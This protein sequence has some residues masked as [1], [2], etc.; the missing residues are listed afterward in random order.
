MS[1]QPEKLTHKT[2][3]ALAEAQSSAV[4]RGHSQLEPTHVFQALLKDEQGLTY[5][6]FQKAGVSLERFK[7]EIGQRV[8]KYPSVS[9]SG[10]GQLYASASFNKLFAQA[11]KEM[12]SLKD[13]YVSVE[14]LLL[15]AASKALK[16]SEIGSIFNTF[17]LSHKKLLEILT[18]IR[19]SHRV[20][21]QS[22]ENKYQ[23]LEKFGRDLTK[24][25]QEQKLDPVIGRDDEIRRTMQILSRRTKNNPVL[26]GSPGVGKTAVVEGLARRI[27]SGDVPEGLKD[28]KLIALDMGALVAGAKYR[29]EFEERLKSVIKEVSD[30]N[31]QIILFIDELHLLVGAGKTEGAMDASNLLK[32]ALA[33]GELRCIGATT[34]DEYRENIE[35]DAALERRFQKTLVDEPSLGETVSILRGLKERYEVHHGIAVRDAALVAAAQLSDRYITDRFLPDKAIDLVDEA[36]ARIRMEAQSRPEAIDNLERRILQLEIEREALKKESDPASQDRLKQAEK[37]LADLKHESSELKALWEKEKTELSSSQQIRQELEQARLELEKAEKEYNHEKAAELRY[38]KIPELE[39]KIEQKLETEQ[40]SDGSS[41]RRLLKEE[42]TEEDIAEVVSRATGIPVSKM[43]EGEHEK[44]LS[45]E[46]YLSKRVVGQ[47]SAIE[48]ISNAVRRSRAGLSD[49]KRPIGSFLFLGPTG[50][51]KTETAKSLAEFLFDDEQAM[52]RIDMSEYMEKHAVARL[53]GAPPGYVGYEQ[54]GALTEAVRR[55]P[56]SVILL[57]E[58]EKAHPEVF[59]IFLQILDDG[60]LTDSHG[61]LV[62]FSNSVIIMTSNVGSQIILGESDEAKRESKV[63][64]ALRGVFKPEFLN[65][66][67]DIVVF[68]A[69]AQEQIKS[70]VEIQLEE[71]KKKLEEKQ[72]ELRVSD[73][74]L[75]HLAK[76][77]FDPDYGARPLRRLI[78]KEIE[79]PLSL[80]L[81]EGQF[82]AESVFLLTVDKGA[83]KIQMPN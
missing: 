32:P 75:D 79:N 54:G 17:Q 34:L 48:S 71:L 81:I 57:D 45:M 80:K 30:S 23:A 31:G 82:G 61:H 1:I 6:V 33:R 41:S 68:K 49:P 28:K 44:L 43:L 19:G 4:S 69:L 83:L 35:K 7:K 51:G 46:A 62:N 66:I 36:C 65:R 18:K 50:V 52:I 67:D 70:I 63:L 9:G 58:I 73:E 15:A 12:E 42:V 40:S 25:A 22:P 37:E 59:N 13:E 47:N 20:T 29:G 8:E 53:I 14:H 16:D 78:Q 10:S 56:Y 60:R 74:A 26:I 21:D 24:D 39:K 5:N 11:Q 64:E 38:G 2:Q 27:A 3:E 76:R 55:K 77:G 72:I